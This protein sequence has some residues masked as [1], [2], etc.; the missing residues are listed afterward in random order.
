[1]V[2]GITCTISLQLNWFENVLRE[3]IGTQKWQ[4]AVQRKLRESH[5]GHPRDKF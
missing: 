2:Y 5:V 4:M 3:P 1:M